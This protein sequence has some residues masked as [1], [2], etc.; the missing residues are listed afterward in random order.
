VELVFDSVS[1]VGP[2]VLDVELNN[3]A[4]ES[5]DYMFEA[6]RIE[7]IPSLLGTSSATFDIYPSGDELMALGE[8]ITPTNKFDMS[9]VN[10]NLELEAEV[11]VSEAGN[12]KLE[13]WLADGNGNLVTWESGAS[14]SLPVG[15]Q[16]LSLTF[17]GSNIRVHGEAGPYQVVALKVLDGDA[18]YEVLDEVAV[19]MTT[20]A[21]TLDQFAG[22]DATVFEDYVAGESGWTAG[23]SW[24]VVQGL[25]QYMGSS[26][27]WRGSNTDGILAL[28]PLDFSTKTDLI[29]R[30]QTGYSFGSGESGYL[31]GSTDENNW[32][33]VR[34]FDSS[35]WFDGTLLIDLDAYTGEPTVYLRF[36]MDS[37]GGG[38]DGWYVDDLLIVGVPDSDGD[39]L[40]DEEEGSADTDGDGVPDYLEPNDDYSSGGDTDNDGIPNHLDTDDDGDGVLTRDEDIDGDGDPTNDDTDGDN[41]PNYLD[42][43][44]DGDGV[45]T[46]DESVDGDNDPRNDDTDGDNIPNYLD[47]DDDG[48][49]ILT[50]NEDID[51][52]GDPANDNT[53]GDSLP[54]YLDPDDDGDSV[55]TLYEGANADGTGQNTDSDGLLDYLDPDDDGDGV[56]TI[57]EMPDPNGNGNPDDA[58]DTDGYYHPNTP[59]YLDPDDDGDGVLTR[60]EDIDDDPDDDGVPDYLDPSNDDSVDDDSDGVNTVDEDWNGDGDP[61]NDVYDGIPSYMDPVVSEAPNMYIFLPIIFRQ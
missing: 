13:A 46:E 3:E 27:A 57:N 10:G 48:D 20:P 41:I 54:N 33:V 30:L 7:L 5:I 60:D 47:T 6:Y 58:R 44:D 43:D 45:L 8:T 50:L 19:A 15:L 9:L 49:G 59:D 29:L 38:S 26:K 61:T 21:Y 28:A 17:L 52:N 12:Y 18:A 16:T 1:E 23:G 22:S 37:A 36:R 35:S 25:H 53:D 14:T 51:G 55:N 56:D 34:S 31:E 2:Y 39:G 11:E 24:A 42:T 40:T 32:D 4:G